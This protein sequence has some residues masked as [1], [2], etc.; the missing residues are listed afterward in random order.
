MSSS[1]RFDH[2]HFNLLASTQL[3]C[4]FHVSAWL[5]SKQFLFFS[6]LQSLKSDVSEL[7]FSRPYQWSLTSVPSVIYASVFHAASLLFAGSKASSL[8]LCHWIRKSVYTLKRFQWCWCVYDGP[9]GPLHFLTTDSLHTNDGG[10]EKE[11]SFPL[12]HTTQS[13]PSGL[14]HS[15]LAITNFTRT[16]LKPATV[17]S[18]PKFNIFNLKSK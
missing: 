8:L 4:G 9:A 10:Q 16:V 17:V 14:R 11:S 2:F 1:I 12:W 7:T 15:P 3:H 18:N 5:S 13:N 6:T